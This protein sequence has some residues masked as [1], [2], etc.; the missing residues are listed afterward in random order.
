LEEHGAPKKPED[1]RPWIRRYWWLLVA[2]VALSLFGVAYFFIPSVRDA[3]DNGVIP[4][5]E[6]PYVFFPVLFVYAILIAVILPIPIEFILLIPAVYTNPAFFLGTALTIGL[7]KAV[8]AWLIFFLGVNLEEQI[9]GWSDRI[10]LVGTLIRFCEWIVK[11][12]RYVGLFVLLSIPMMSD[13]AV[14]YVFALFNP[15]A[16]NDA[17][18][19]P[20]YERHTLKMIPFV[21]TNFLGGITR[22]ALFVFLVRF[23]GWNP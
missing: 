5:L 16:A 11:K 12:T 8:G 3:L 1:G 22:V 21:V 10:K 4:F 14:L 2:I 13:T 18:G 9:R 20:V 19:R 23:L 17:N 15:P 7:G 6:N